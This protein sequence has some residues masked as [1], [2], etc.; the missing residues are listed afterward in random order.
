MKKILSILLCVLLIM[1]LFNIT[2]AKAET[3]GTTGECTWA[4]DGTTLTI[5]GNGAMGDYS[6]SYECTSP[7]GSSITSIIFE[8]GVTKIGDYS[9]YNCTNLTSITIPK[10]V[11]KIGNYAFIF[12]S[13]LSNVNYK[14]TIKSA[15]EI[16]ICDGNMSVIE[17]NWN[18][19][20]CKNHNVTLEL[21]KKAGYHDD[22]YKQKYCSTCNEYGSKKIINGYGAISLSKIRYTYNGKIKTPKVIVKDTAGKTISSK[23]YK[24]TYKSSRKYVGKHKVTVK[25]TGNYSGTKSTYFTIYPSSTTIK[26]LT[27]YK[28]S[29]KV[30]I[31]KKKSQTSGYQIQW[32]RIYDLSADKKLLSGYSNTTYTIKR[33]SRNTIYLVKVRTY[34]TVRGKRYYSSWSTSSHTITK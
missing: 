10:S 30:Y 26:K 17:T 29:I 7:W 22:G 25:F 28:K 11:T 21:V 20:G 16:E 3:T 9:F 4:L 13:N 34:K 1:P 32:S 31:N 14:G 12:C 24:I 33:L 18:Y 5:S 8:D 2:I 15:N 27:P 19:E 23:Y 6:D